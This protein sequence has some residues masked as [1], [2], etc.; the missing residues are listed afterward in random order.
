ME[1]LTAG[2][3][4][5][6]TWVVGKLIDWSTDKTFDIASERLMQLIKQKSPDTAKT[7]TAAAGRAALVPDERE[8][9]G[10]AVLVEEVKKAA[11]KDPEI[12]AAVQALGN[13]VNQTVK[14]NTEVEKRL[15]TVIENW[16]GINI[17]GGKPTI[18]NNT[19]NFGNK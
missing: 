19:F 2:A 6:T 13:D 7:L 11:A 1:P 8:D 9:I 5:F 17:K 10:E 12:K 15:T 4:A 3:I 16:Q 14:E 18:S